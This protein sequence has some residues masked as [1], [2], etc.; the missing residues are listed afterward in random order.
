MS[1]DFKAV[2]FEEAAEHLQTIEDELLVL[3]GD[4][5]NSEALDGVFRAAHSIKGSAGMFG[6]RTLSDFT[7]HLETLLDKIRKGTADLTDDRI[8]L[9]LAGVDEIRALVEKL[10]DGEDNPPADNALVGQ[11]ESE[12]RSVAPATEESAPEDA[13]GNA[14]V[15]E[16]FGLFDDSDTDDSGADEEDPGFG[17]FDEPSSNVSEE[18]IADSADDG[19]YGLFDSDDAESGQGGGT[20]DGYHQYFDEL[21]S[22]GETGETGETKDATRPDESANVAAAGDP[23]ADPDGKFGWLNRPAKQASVSDGAAAPSQKTETKP[24]ASPKRARESSGS[25][26]VSLEKVDQLV[27]QISE[28]VI[29]QAML[30]ETAESLDAVENEQHLASLE[31]LERTA[32]ELQES[33]LSIRLLPVKVLFSRFP[34]VV[35]DLSRKLGKEI[36]LVTLGEEAELDKSL[37]EK[38]ADPLTH[39]VRNSID[40]GIESP[41]KRLE[42]QK[43][44]KGQVVMA[45]SHEG[46]DIVISISDDG[47]GIN[48]EKVL[49]KAQENGLDAN[50]EMD[51]DQILNLIFAPGFSTAAEVTDVS[52]RGVG[53]DVVKRNIKELGGRIDVKSTPGEGSV[54]TVRLPLTLAITDGMV[55]RFADQRL[56]IPLSNVVESLQLSSGDVFY[57]QG[58]GCVIRRHGEFVPL[59]TLASASQDSF[60]NTQVGGS[61]LAI[62]VESEG[63][64]IGL[65]VDELIGQQQI[66]IKNLETNYRRVPGFSGATVMGD[67]SVAFIIDVAQLVADST[68]LSRPDAS[69]IGSDLVE[70]SEENL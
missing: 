15:D 5:K 3:D 19:A 10:E 22:E 41:E 37:I 11:L 67:G 30:R 44:Q 1:E 57:V 64:Q 36:D 66:V 2:F 59:Y 32:R 60:K 54:F 48:R 33:V 12:N 14:E 42:A 63:R 20:S 9:V 45:A 26:R 27:N 68:L 24:S 25:L 31:T 43:P 8:D 23:Q 34:R 70:T 6:F 18:E 69:L 13:S 7:H 21:L 28:L 47:A 35:R 39:L 53:M 38:L 61:L 55:L 46:G 56:V 65:L 52:G 40:H 49:K 4:R 51:E 58:D 29:T 50:E 17:L 62:I 16:S